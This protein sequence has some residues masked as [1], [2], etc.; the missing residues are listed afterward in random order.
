M[1]CALTIEVSDLIRSRGSNFLDCNPPPPKI[2]H[3][4][5]AGIY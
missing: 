1:R 4:G 2:S 3:K 5:S